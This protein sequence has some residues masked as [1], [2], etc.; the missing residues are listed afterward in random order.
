VILLGD[1]TSPGSDK[2]PPTES[3]AASTDSKLTVTGNESITSFQNSL[4]TFEKQ[5]KK[6]DL[7]AVA[8]CP[9]AQSVDLPP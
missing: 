5:L 7:A 2:K 1:Y 6:L 4:G 8:E 3:V 9:Q